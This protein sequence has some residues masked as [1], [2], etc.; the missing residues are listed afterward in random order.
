MNARSNFVDF[1][2]SALES[3]IRKELDRPDG[4]VSFN[5]LRAIVNLDLNDTAVEDI[6]ALAYCE[7]LEGL[8]LERT[9]VATLIPLSS[10]KQLRLLSIN[11][12]KVNDLSPI[13]KLACLRELFVGKT[14]VSDISA[15]SQ[16]HKL[17]I[18]S[19]AYSPVRSVAP[20]ME[21]LEGGGLKMGTVYLYAVPLCDHSRYIVVPS[22]VKAGVAVHL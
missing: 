12:T 20:L 1:R 18:V 9:C 6:S 19:F 22:L 21:V 5:D 10:C 4:A 7:N 8:A 16:L 11:G 15:L 3:A 2:D 14:E 13:R 17:R